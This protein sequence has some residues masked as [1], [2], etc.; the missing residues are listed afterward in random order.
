MDIIETLTPAERAEHLR[1]P[2][3]AVGLAV[4]HWNS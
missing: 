3:G 4:A 1:E 2:E